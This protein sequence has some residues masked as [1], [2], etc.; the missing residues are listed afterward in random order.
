MKEFRAA[1]H[2]KIL[3]L[4]DFAKLG[5][6]SSEE[7]SVQGADLGIVRKGP[8]EADLRMREIHLGNSAMHALWVFLYSSESSPILRIRET[9]TAVRSSASL[10]T[11]KNADRQRELP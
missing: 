5:L 2:I 6:S 4:F 8:A 10:N 1:A 7:V 3:L 11:S 9:G